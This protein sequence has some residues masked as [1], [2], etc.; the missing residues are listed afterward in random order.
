MLTVAGIGLIAA[1]LRLPFIW[2]GIG[3]DE[4]GY[5]FIAHQWAQGAHLYQ[6]VWV[7]RPQGLLLLFRAIT[8]IAYT[9]AAIRFAAV[10]AGASVAIVLGLIGW[11][12]SSPAAGIAAAAIY[13]VV[14]VGP[15]MEGFTMNAEL[16]AAVPAAGAVACA[17]RW[18]LAGGRRWLLAAG[19][20]GGGAVLMKQ[21]GF[22]GLVTAAVFA[23]GMAGSQRERIA[24]AGLVLAGAV[25]PLGAATLDGLALG[26]SRYWSAIYGWRVHEGLG[27]TAAN[28][29]HLIGFALPRVAPDLVAITVVAVLGVVVC[30]RRGGILGL[31]PLWVLVAFLGINVGGMYW[32]HYFVQLV[33]PLALLAAIGASAVW[34]RRPL[35]A[36]LLICAAVAPVVVTL[37]RLATLS[38]QERDNEI[39]YAEGFKVGE[40]VAH[41]VR[42]N[43]TERDTF[44][45][46][47]SRADLYFLSDRRPPIPY[48]WANSPL[49]RSSTVMELLRDLSRPGRP[50]FVAVT[51]PPRKIDATGR[52]QRLLN[53][54]YTFAWRPPGEHG[55]PLLIAHG[56][57]LAPT[58]P[59]GSGQRNPGH[60]PNHF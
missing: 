42:A 27:Q 51:G 41:F 37:A 57:T 39:T 33:P 29:L 1:L 20:L 56:A 40:Q 5:A 19:M 10:L 24:R 9:P 47:G 11:M 52:L 7:D 12:L 36:V 59:P 25:L 49:L 2:T 38:R 30:V 15:H 6:S 18:R 13:A 58:T 4:G 45:V 26:W 35:L 23:A 8:D 48:L 53:K 28:R 32:P 46:L 44:Y 22:D 3:P 31:C 54:Y 34:V 50:K 17:V 14:G 60:P 43:S 21:S 55:T 16:A